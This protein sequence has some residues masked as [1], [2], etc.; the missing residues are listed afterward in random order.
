[1]STQA[2]R[3]RAFH[4]LHVP[5]KPVVLY[6]VW[7]PGSAKA[8]DA[9][10]ADALATGSASVAL[11]NGFSD[12]EQVPFDLVLGNAARIV[13]ATDLPVS[14]DLE[15][16][17]GAD[18]ATVGE[19]VAQV[20][21]VGIIG[22]NIEDSLIERGPL[23]DIEA[24]CARLR[25][26]R[27]AADRAGIELFIN[28]RTDVFFQKPEAEHDAAMAEEAI[29]RAKAY[30]EAGADGLFTPLLHDPTLI[31][32]VAAESPLPLNIITWDGRASPADLAKLG[33]ARV[34]Y[35]PAPYR[36]TMKA[37]Q[38]AAALVFE[39]RSRA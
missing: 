13:A 15:R 23:R 22:C 4:A 16:G 36:A 29:A 35:G 32:R 37:L 25:A 18:A 21:G 27:A 8:V 39:S 34:S 20:I 14:L 19:S 3:A 9:A 30:A 33:V 24:Q 10:G 17:Y 2:A 7:D 1:M 12:G 28:A 38:N 26:A 5:G 6:N 11:A 31:G